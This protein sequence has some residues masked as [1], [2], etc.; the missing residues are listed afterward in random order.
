MRPTTFP[1]GARTAL[2]LL[3]L[4]ILG[5]ALVI[6]GCSEKEAGAGAYYCP[7]H[8]TYVSDRPGD[9]PICNMRLVPRQ[10]ADSTQQAM[11]GSGAA[12]P[13]GMES[14]AH[15]GHVATPRGEMPAADVPGMSTVSIDAR[16]RQLAGIQTAVAQR[17]PLLQ[18]V[19]TA[20]IVLA[21]ETQ[22]RH[23]HTRID[24]FVE[25]LHVAAIGQFV[26]HGDPLLEIYSPEL[27]ASQEEFLRVRETAARFAT[28][29]LPEVR[30]GGA[31]LLQA[32]RRRLELYEVPESFIAALERS[33]KVQRTVTLEAHVSGYVTVKSVAE[34]MH[35]TPGADLYTVTDLSRIWVE[36]DFY[37][38]EATLVRVGQE[39]RLRPSYAPSREI[40][41]RVSYVYPYLDPSTRT[42]KVRFEFPNPD[43]V[44]KPAMFVDVTLAVDSPPVVTVP[45]SAILDSGMRRLVF[46]EVQANRFEP[47]LVVVGR[48]SGEMA[49]IVSGV[50]AGEAVVVRA[51]FLLDS[52]SR[53]RGALS[54]MGGAHQH[55]KTP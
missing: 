25:K 23:I 47:R 17:A 13:G 38:N 53:L 1:R 24:G 31:D 16:G 43:L 50:D 3:A 22:V 19:R 12:T 48:R 29:E 34:G 28:S 27:L 35:V 15:D 2:A 20:G 10:A 9:C 41:G 26:R 46:V 40:M 11:H 39:A 4:L 36:A 51:N 44:L 45:E 14:G 49:E 52:E 21:D 5:L 54:G 6:A 7:M 33:G 18:S 32:A 42:L 37:E 30:K 55:G 8:P